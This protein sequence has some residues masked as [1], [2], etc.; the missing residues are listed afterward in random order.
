MCY[1][2]NASLAAFVLGSLGQI[3]LWQRGT[4]VARALALGIIPLTAMQA[5]EFVMWKNPCSP[6]APSTLNKYVSRV[7][8]LTNYAQPL[9]ISALLLAIKRKPSKAL[10]FG[11]FAY[12]C[13]LS[14][15]VA[16]NWMKVTCSD[17]VGTAPNGNVCETQTCGLHWQWVQ[18]INKFSWVA[19]FVLLH[20][21]VLAVVK[22][23]SSALI[24]LGFID[25]SFG[26]AMALHGEQRT[27]GSHWC[28]YAVALPWLIAFLPLT[29]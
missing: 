22:P 16:T 21:S 10:L 29:K 17:A 15:D 5:Y 28:F 12:A 11:V 26:L 14:Y 9:I 3:V 8:M 6:N 13:L 23:P 19:Y 7:A 25:V 18:S 1:S 4:P 24:I 27:V 20:A 2:A